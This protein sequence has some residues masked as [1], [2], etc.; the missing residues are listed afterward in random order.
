M[1][2]HMTRENKR[3]H[4]ALEDWASYI[5]LQGSSEIGFAITEWKIRVQTPPRALV[6][7]VAFTP[8]TV[9]AVE[10]WYSEATE[11]LKRH[12]RDESAQRKIVPYGRVGNHTRVPC[13]LTAAQVAL[14][15][16]VVYQLCFAPEHETI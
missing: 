10:N 6:P 13:R 12:G 7:R 14:D 15:G 9:K 1:P 3:A 16:A 8:P 11:T 4:S 5:H 2:A